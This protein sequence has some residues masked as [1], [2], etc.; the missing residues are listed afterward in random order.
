MNDYSEMT[1]DEFNTLLIE[2]AEKHYTVEMLVHAHCYEALSEELN[3]DILA[4]WK[5]RRE[6]S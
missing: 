6:A 2:L 3:N 5:E 4:L 1:Y